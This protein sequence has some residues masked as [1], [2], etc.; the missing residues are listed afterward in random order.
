[1]DNDWPKIA[2]SGIV[3]L[4]LSLWMSCPQVTPIWPHAETTALGKATSMQ[5]PETF[6]TAICHSKFEV[7][8]ALAFKTM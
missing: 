3:R 5:G 7:L 6:F 2:R 8:K 4:I 1:M